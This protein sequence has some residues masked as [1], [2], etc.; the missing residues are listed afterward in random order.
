MKSKLI[1]LS[2]LLSSAEF[3]SSCSKHRNE[4]DETKLDDKNLTICAS[5]AGCS[6]LF[7]EQ[8]DFEGYT[9]LKPGTF[10]VFWSEQE[11]TGITTTLYIKAP[12]PGKSFELTK[13]DILAGKIQFNRSCPSCYMAA[14]NPVDGYVKGINATPDKPADQTKWLVEA[15]IFLQAQ[16]YP[17]LKDTVFIK[18]YFEPNFVLN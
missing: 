12:M 7:T 3:F 6:F 18:Q 1:L 4:K 5:G 8:A 9:N 14:F 10:R 11:K 15:K 2:L 17:Q 16:E 13:T